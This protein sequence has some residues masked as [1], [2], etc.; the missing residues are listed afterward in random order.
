MIH[1]GIGPFNRYLLNYVKDSVCFFV[2]NIVLGL[3]SEIRESIF[4]GTVVSQFD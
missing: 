3:F 2:E 1:N 4:N